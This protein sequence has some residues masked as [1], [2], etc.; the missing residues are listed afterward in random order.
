MYTEALA[1]E[2]AVRDG[3]RRRRRDRRDPGRRPRRRRRVRSGGAALPD[4]R[5]QRQRAVAGRTPRARRVRAVRAAGRQG[6]RACGCCEAGR[7]RIPTSKLAEQV[8][9]QLAR[10]ESPAPL[11]R[12]TGGELEAVSTRRK[13]L[14]RPHPPSEGERAR[15][16]GP[17]KLATI[18][19][20][21]RT[22]LA[23][24]VRITIELDGEVPFHDERI[25]DPS[26]VFVDL[27]GT[28]AAPR[29]ARSHAPLRERRRRRAAGPPRPPSEQHH[30]RRAR[31]RRRD[32]ATASIRSTTRIASSSIACAPSAAATAAPIAAPSRP[33]AVM[34]RETRP[35]AA[36]PSEPKP[37]VVAPA[38][39]LATPL[40]AR[41]LTTLWL[42]R[43]PSASPHAAKLIAAARA[44]DEPCRRRSSP[45]GS[46]S[47][48]RLPRRR[49]RR[50]C[51]GQQIAEAASAPVGSHGGETAP[52]VLGRRSLEGSA[53]PSRNLNGGFSIA[54]QLGL[55]V[56]RI[57]IDPGHGG[58]DPGAMGKGVTEA[59]LVL[60]VALRLE[61]LL[62]KA[63]GR[64]GHPDAP[65]RRVHPAAGADGDREPRRRRSVPLDS[66]QRQRERAGARR[67]NLLP[68]LREQPDRGG[69][70]GARKRRV[71]PGDGRAARFRQGHRA[72]QQAR[73]VARLRHPR[74]ARDGG[75]AAR[76]RTRR[77]GISA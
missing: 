2:Q 67:R 20:I 38:P 10:V 16:A 1:R 65:D 77:S 24:A 30:A 41:R 44:V 71:R 52:T 48:S 75:A 31:R 6:H 59:E 58:H 21:R 53:P 63:A 49:R 9:A 28:R 70:G 26:R 7:R 57:V 12:A 47:P 18:K 76:R 40:A 74:A 51:L 5:L 43:L 39:R 29:S 36:L 27:P 61:K 46:W 4:Q 69:G 23:D 33:A 3:A 19:D 14:D 17:A 64:R 50:R 73:R 34:P 22:V 54:R 68:E 35:P 25:A 56:S 42:R 60:D 62:Q 37:P 66:R 72:E 11:C 32:R 15:A 45:T 8:P 13:P 55:G